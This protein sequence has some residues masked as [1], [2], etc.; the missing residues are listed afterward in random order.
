MLEFRQLGGPARA[1]AREHDVD[2]VAGLLRL[3]SERHALECAAE[4]VFAGLRVGCD[5]DCEFHGFG[6]GGAAELLGMKPTTL[7]SRLRA[8]GIDRKQV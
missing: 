8:L 2:V 5:D 6:A 3:G 4:A 7:A 1:G